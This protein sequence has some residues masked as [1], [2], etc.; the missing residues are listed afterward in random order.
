[1]QVTPSG[2]RVS[3]AEGVIQVLCQD[4]R[5]KVMKVIPGT[6]ASMLSLYRAL[7]GEEGGVPE[8]PG[9]GKAT[10]TRD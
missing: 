5:V 6:G 7:A 3:L 8:A 9:A 10:Y 1:M 4:G 2:R